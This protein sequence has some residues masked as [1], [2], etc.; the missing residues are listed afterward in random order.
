MSQ[1]RL[2]LGR[3]GTPNI[4]HAKTSDLFE[5]HSNA[6]DPNETLPIL[7]GDFKRLFEQTQ[8]P[9]NNLHDTILTVEGQKVEPIYVQRQLLVARSAYFENLFENE[10]NNQSNEYHLEQDEDGRL[11]IKFNQ[12]F[13]LGLDITLLREIIAYLYWSYWE[14]RFLERTKQLFEIA[15]KLD[16]KE[17]RNSTGEDLSNNLNTKN[18]ADL[19]I[20]AEEHGG[21]ILKKKC[22]HFIIEN[23]AQID[24]KYL[25]QRLLKFEFGSQLVAELY[26]ENAFSVK[27]N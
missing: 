13:H 5:N 12:N 24:S 25:E 2:S 10:K 3:Y 27:A 15:S 7:L 14:P 21:K 11:V 6:L 8:D 9:L 20:A 16:L 18:V 19:L 17:L 22:I 23:K 26:K 4:Y 1:S